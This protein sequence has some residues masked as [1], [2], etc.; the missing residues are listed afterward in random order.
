MRASNIFYDGEPTGNPSDGHITGPKNIPNT[1]MVDASNMFKSSDQLQAYFTP[2]A[3]D[4]SKEVVTYCFIGQTASVVY[5]AG[6]MLGYSMK[7][8]D[9]SL[10]EWSRLDNLPKEVTKK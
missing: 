4:K 8:Y 9:G 2:V 1:E 6:R 5:M 10:Q 3:P 7:L